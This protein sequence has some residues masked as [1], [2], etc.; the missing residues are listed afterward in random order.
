MAHMSAASSLSSSYLS[1]RLGCG[2]TGGPAPQPH[3]RGMGCSPARLAR[4]PRGRCARARE[5]SL[6]P[7]RDFP[8]C[9]RIA[10]PRIEAG[11]EE[12]A[13]PRP[14]AGPSQGSLGLSSRRSWHRASKVGQGRDPS[15]Q[16]TNPHRGFPF[17]TSEHTE[18]GR[19]QTRHRCVEPREGAAAPGRRRRAKD[20]DYNRHHEERR[21]GRPRWE[22]KPDRSGD[23]HAVVNAYTA[24]NTFATPPSILEPATTTPS[25][26]RE[27]HRGPLPLSSPLIT[28]LSGTDGV[29]VR[30]RV[31]LPGCRPSSPSTAAPRTSGALGPSMPPGPPSPCE[32]HLRSPAFEPSMLCRE[33]RA[34]PHRLVSRPWLPGGCAE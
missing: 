24:A 22:K 27:H 10:N 17:F 20:D 19:E 33:R 34:P 28:S 18:R 4:T 15:A 2:R 26:R 13:P 9:P 1:P 6:S 31:S 21:G 16:A 29:G 11:A 12:G 23:I 30:R 25:P 7:E 5:S 3:A 8:F 32:D 14:P